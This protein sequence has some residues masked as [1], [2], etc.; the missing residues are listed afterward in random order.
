NTDGSFKFTLNDQIDHPLHSHDDGT[1]PPGALEET[2]FLDLANAVGGHDLSG[3]PIVLNGNSF[4][5]GVVDDT[6]IA[7][8]SEPPVFTSGSESEPFFNAQIVDDENQ[9][10]PAS[11]GIPGGAGEDGN[12]T[13]RFRALD[14]SPGADDYGTVPFG[15]TVTATATDG[16]HTQ[17]V[18]K[19]QAIFVDSNGVGHKQ[20]ITLTWTPDAFGGGTLTGSTTDIPTA[21]TLTADKFGAYT[22]TPYPPLPHPFHRNPND[23]NS[24]AFEDNLKLVFTYTATDLDGDSADAHLTINVDDD[25]PT[26][27]V[28]TNVVE[29]NDESATI[30]ATLV[31]DE[32]PGVQSA[33]GATDVAGS[34]SISF[35]GGSTPVSALFSGVVNKGF[36]PDVFHDHGAI[37]FAAGSAPLVTAHVNFGADGAA[38]SNAEVFSLTLPQGNGT[39]SGLQTTEG[40][41]IYLFLE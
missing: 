9:N 13:V 12:T 15:T 2:L 14:F 41:E 4:D 11:P 28:Q 18:D 32:T 17:S 39:D 31:H 21:F 40:R 22:F 20:D 36:D 23:S 37:G 24:H 8:D 6:P 27:C 35:N 10:N 7:H 26:L 1:N 16:V 33:N 5:I 29:G 30:V 25:L 19:L 3:D 38:E 34:T